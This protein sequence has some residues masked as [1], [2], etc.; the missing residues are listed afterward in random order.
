[1]SRDDGVFWFLLG[2][3][4]ADYAGWI[5][6]AVVC[7]LVDYWYFLDT[8]EFIRNTAGILPSLLLAAGAY[9]LI[10]PVTYRALRKPL[11]KSRV[12]YALMLANIV[13]G[14]IV[15]RYAV[16]THTDLGHTAWEAIKWVWYF[17]PDVPLLVEIVL[18]S[19]EMMAILLIALL[20]ISFPLWSI[21]FYCGLQFC[22][23]DLIRPPLKPAN[24]EPRLA[25]PRLALPSRPPRYSIAPADSTREWTGL[26]GARYRYWAY[27]IGHQFDDI[28]GNFLFIRETGPNDCVMRYAGQTASLR[29]RLASHEREA[30]ELGATHI[31]AHPS[32]PDEAVRAA[33]QNDIVGRCF[34]VRQ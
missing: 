19:L 6:A 31:H 20:F 24:V 10:V 16:V 28:P 32:V 12:F 22:F 34:V 30:R 5:A 11:A 17:R 23:W 21:A 8:T 2:F 25:P 14:F 3:M 18:F 26:S 4:L 29:S 13:I 27:P 9:T 33:E 15:I 7:G 1:M